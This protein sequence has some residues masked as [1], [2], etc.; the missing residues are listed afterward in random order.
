MTNQ[1]DKKEGLKIVRQFNAPKAMVFDAFSTAEAFEEWWGPVG[2]S[3]KVVFFDFKP[4]GKVHYKMEAN[5]Q[6]MWGVFNYKKIVRPDLLEFISSFSDESG[7][8]SKAPFPIDFPLEIFN[9]ITFEE[10]NG[11]TTLTLTG[12]PV[13]ATA[14]QEATYHSMFDN[15]T[16]GF[17][18]TLNQLEVYL[19]KI[20]K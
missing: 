2:M 11:K 16:K 1:S 17:T 13:N 5:G 6:I 19:N 18:G 14:E 7:N 10:E 15:M 8:V 20:Q 3:L 12:H 4:G 9:Q